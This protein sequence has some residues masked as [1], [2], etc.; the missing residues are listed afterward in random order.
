MWA[1]SF[2]HTYAAKLYKHYRDVFVLSVDKTYYIG[3]KDTSLVCVIVML[4][5]GIVNRLKYMLQQ[6]ITNVLAILVNIGI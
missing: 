4:A 2:Y 6:S 3:Y 1:G 5:G